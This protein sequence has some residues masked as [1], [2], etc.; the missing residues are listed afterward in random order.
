MAIT[1]TENAV[2]FKRVENLA[3]S[4]QGIKEECDRLKA[5]AA[6][7]GGDLSATPEHAVA[8]LVAFRDDVINPLLT[9][10]ADTAFQT[11]FQEFM[12]LPQV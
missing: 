11:A 2:A 9:L 12:T 10:Y 7:F 8:D 3:A 1:D 5:F 6:Q 4:I